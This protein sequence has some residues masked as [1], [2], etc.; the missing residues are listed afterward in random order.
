MKSNLI[1]ILL[2]IIVSA[3]VGYVAFDSGRK[4]GIDEAMSLR[5]AFLQD[6]QRFP[7]A[8]QSTPGANPRQG[9]GQA[10]QFGQGN[11]ANPLAALFTGILG[12]VDKIE[13]NTLTVTLTRGQQTQTVKVTLGDKATVETFVPGSLSDVKVGSRILVGVDRPQGQQGQGQFQQQIPSDVTARTITILP[14]SLSGQQP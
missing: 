13:G 9:Q 8:A 2:A 1:I 4:S 12:T 5:N 6:A 7:G 3:C 11:Q 10:G 14:T